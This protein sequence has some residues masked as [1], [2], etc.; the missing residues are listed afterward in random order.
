MDNLKSLKKSRA[1]FKAKLTVFKDYLNALLPS[2]ELNSVQM[3]ELT[4]RHAKMSEMYNDFDSIQNDIESLTEIPDEEYAER[5]SFEDRY[6]GAMAAAQDLLSKHAAP[7]G[8]ASAEHDRGSVSG[9]GDAVFS[10]KPNIKLP[11]IHLPTF[12][13]RYQDWLEYHDTYKSLI[14]NNTSIPNI[15]KFHYL[16]NSLKD[17]ASLI[18]KSLEF[19]TENYDVAWDLLCERFNN[20]R[21]LVNNHIQALFSIKPVTQE[22]S[23]ALRNMIDWVNKNLRALKTLKLPTEHWDV[24]IIHMMSSKL[25]AVSMRDWETERNKI[26]GI[27]T[28]SDFTNFL[29]GRADLLETMEEAQMQSK[30]PRRQSDVT[31]NR[32]RT[33]VVNESKQ[34]QYKCPVCANYHTIYQCSKFKAM[35]IESRIDK[36]KQLS[37]CTNC[38][39]AGHD[40]PRCRLSSCRLCTNRHNTLLHIN[41]Q[42]TE[43]LASKSSTK[44]DCVLPCVQDQSKPAQDNITLSSIHCSQ[45]LLSTAIVNVQDHSGQTHKVRVMLD[46]GSTISFITESLQKQLG[47]PS[48]S[49]F[50]SVNLLEDKSTTTTKKCD[51]TISSLY[52]RN[53]TTDVDC[54]VL[55]RVTDVIPTNPINC[56]AFKI[57]SHIHLADPSFSEP[58]EVQMLLS[59][60]IFWDVLCQNKISLGKNLP[61]L[62]ETKLGWLVVKLPYSNKT[63]QNTVHCHFSNTELDQKLN[64]FFDDDGFSNIEKI[65]NKSKTDSECERIFTSTTTRH[66]DGKFVVTV[67]LKESPEVLGN[68][69]EQALTRFHSLERKFKREPEFK[70][71]Y[72]KFMNEYL[73]LG[74]MSENKDSQNDTFSY[75]LPHHGI[76]REGSLTTKL[77]SVF[78]GSAVTSSGKSYNDIQHIGPVVQ[79]D[80]LSILIRFRQHRFVAT[81]DVAKMYRQIYVREDQ[82]SLQQILWRSDP[83]QPIN[84]YKLNTVTYGTASAP[85][86]ATRTLK[87]LG[88]DCKDELARETILHDFYVDDYITGHDNEQTLIHTCQNVISELEP[89]HFHLRKWRSNKP[90]ILNQIIN[91]NNY[92]DLLNLNNDEYA[93]TL[94]LLWACKRDTLL[95]SLPNTIQN[96]KTKRAILSTIAQVFDPLGLINPCMLQAKLILQALWSQNIPW[97][98]QLPGEVESQWDQFVKYLPD[99]SKIEI[100]RRAL[101]D[102]FVTVQLHAFSDASMKAYAAC[103]YLRTVS[104]SG[105]VSVHLLV[106][107]SKLAPLRQR[108]TIPKLELCGSLLATQ[109]TKKVVNSLRLEIDSI[110]F[111]CDSTIVLGWLKTCKKQLKQFVHN[112]VTEITNAFDPSAW[113][114]VP[115]D[116]NPAD[117]G[118]RGQNALQLKNSTLWFQGP[119]FLHQKDIQWPLQP[120]SVNV[121]DLPEIKTHCHISAAADIQENDFTEKFSNFSKMQRVVAYMYRFK[122]N[123]QN[124]NKRFG[125]LRISELKL[126]LISLCKKVQSEIFN[127]QFL[128]L[129]KGTLTTKDKIIKLNPFIDQDNLI[130]VGG[131]LSNSNYD[132]DTKHPIL[133]H[134]SHHITKTLVQHYHKIHLH[135]GPQLLLSMLRHKFWII[136]GRNLC[137]KI[138]HDCLTCL[139][140]SGRTYQPIMSPLPA[141]RLHAD[142]PFTHTATDYAGPIL[143]LN[144]KGRGAQ[145]IK[146]YIVVFVCLAVR[147]VHLELVTDLTSQG[148]IAALNRFIARRG[149]PATLLSDNGTQYV[150][151]CN[152]LAKF[153]KENSNDITA[154]SAENEIK[155]K[156]AP[157]YSPNFNGLSEGSVKSVKYHL[158]RVLSMT[159]LDYEHMNSALVHIEGTLNSRPLTPLSSD[160]SDLAPLCPAHFLIGRTI[161]LPPAPQVEET[162]PLTTLSKYMR[163]QQLKA[164]FWKRYSKEYISELQSRSK[165]RTQGAHPQLGEMVIIKDDRLPPNRWLL[166]RVTAVHPGSDG[167]NRVA[168]ILTTTGTL[169][170]AYNRLCPLPSTLDQAAPDPRG[171]AC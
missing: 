46:N 91:E 116:M 77:R 74:H 117:I 105:N 118:S 82:R 32:P 151:S 159:N 37:L 76:L 13:G 9:S 42:S 108:L 78:D 71:Q 54:Y 30:V 8:P 120:Q 128:L 142:H 44:S 137:R 103:V 18:I 127:K 47:I 101:C 130:R 100:P 165:W 52:D 79:D 119:H 66:S 168:D 80:L 113:H 56:N 122:H 63:K 134:A 110:Y 90:S 67:P 171:P 143:I 14:H 114:Y 43:P 81:S 135:A 92:D 170:R 112:R 59:A 57:P 60:E 86:L 20:D 68:S 34:K 75:F 83:T 96:P 40:E 12:S 115:T 95:F 125:P 150:G 87:Q 155:F 70:E 5:T 133:L 84:Q 11:T 144:R 17:S 4:L 160:P 140:F 6:F 139:R 3:Q 62:V 7:A 31:H 109:L 126:A 164:H 167:V 102:D 65:C 25:D 2:S 94:G 61:T 50:T 29:K 146:A 166:G 131:R 36:I 111:H 85:W 93:K 162:R 72:T 97:D 45:T 145:L 38:L 15:H 104:K 154:Y 1:S 27:P 33:F 28:F 121:S 73:Q 58:S 22:S 99:I 152:E 55:S 49:T 141:Q 148:F 163:V 16:R 89:A 153:L 39:R 158:K 24:L 69:K 136:S 41:T 48:Y 123:C 53:Y 19:S 132:Y 147:A 161:T 64:N 26:V 157:A 124:T 23:K 21:I 35:S 106:A 98:S 169:R 129:T 51:V 149:K 156:F 88:I 10:S 107:K 138:T